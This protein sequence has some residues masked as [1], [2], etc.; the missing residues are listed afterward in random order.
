MGQATPSYICRP[1]YSSITIRTLAKH[2]DN[3]KS[4]MYLHPTSEN[5]QLSC[6]FQ[7]LLNNLIET[8]PY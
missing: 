5:R 3:M 8:V 4:S 1:C 6:C 7:G 2:D